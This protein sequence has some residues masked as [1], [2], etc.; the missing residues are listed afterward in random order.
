MGAK[1]ETWYFCVI[2]LPIQ[3]LYVVTLLSNLNAR[4]YVRGKL[5]EW[6]EYLTTIPQDPSIQK[7]IV[8][9]NFHSTNC[10]ADSGSIEA[11]VN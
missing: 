5:T 10:S 1:P 3:S 4:S 6:D 2:E 11:M 7:G 9:A 8:F